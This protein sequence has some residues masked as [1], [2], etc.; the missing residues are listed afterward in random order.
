MQRY[1]EV[2][3]YMRQENFEPKETFW[4][5]AT[6]FAYDVLHFDGKFF[7]TLKYLL[8][9]PVFITRIFTWQKSKLFAS[10]KMYVFTSAIFF[11]IF[12]PYCKDR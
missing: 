2:L 10:Y 8:L 1:R 4:M 11:I 9:K 6:H 12:F 7:S 5:L 3:P